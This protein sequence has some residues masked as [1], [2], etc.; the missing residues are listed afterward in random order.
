M[1]SKNALSYNM[2]FFLLHKLAH[3]GNSMM[4]M[5]TITS[6]SLQR[7]NAAVNCHSTGRILVADVAA[8]TTLHPTYSVL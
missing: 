6:L 2:Q 4:E 5:T 8:V 3:L 7:H 1:P